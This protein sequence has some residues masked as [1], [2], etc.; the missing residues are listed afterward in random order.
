MTE[1]LKARRGSGTQVTQAVVGLGKDK[2]QPN[3]YQLA[4]T[5]T[6]PVAM[7]RKVLIQEARQIHLLHLIQQQREIIDAFST[8]VQVH[9]LTV[10]V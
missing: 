9:F 2:A 7:G 1:G 10:Q 3:G 4:Q 5:E 8:D 6:S